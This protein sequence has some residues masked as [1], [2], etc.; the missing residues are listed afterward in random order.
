MST[1]PQWRQLGEAGRGEAVAG[2]KRS[3]P[4]PL[5]DAGQ[6]EDLLREQ[7]Q[8]RVAAAGTPVQPR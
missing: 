2:R 7:A 6:V 1:P 3:G 5:K 8:G 4:G